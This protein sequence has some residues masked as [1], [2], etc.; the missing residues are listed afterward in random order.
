MDIY[1]Q[2][3][4][5]PVFRV[6]DVNQF[7]NNVNSARSAIYRLIGQGKVLKIRNDLYTCVSAERGGPV[8]N[9]YQIAGAI[10]KTSYISHH[11][12]MEYYGL[13]EQLYY[14]VY[15]SS[16]TR[17]CDFLFEDNYYHFV[18]S[19]LDQGVT[20]LPFSGGIKVT[21][22]E[23]TLVDCLKDMDKISGLE[24]T[25][26]MISNMVFLDEKKLLTY[27]DA[28]NNHFLYQKAGFMLW[29]DRDTLNLS[30]KFFD[31]CHS[32]IGKSKRYLTKDPFESVFDSYWN[33]VIPKHYMHIRNSEAFENDI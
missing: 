20:T 32:N 3:A 19:R 31:K 22:R 18:S 25:T 6:N 15:V 11:T 30:E 26:K 12:A 27:L 4:K 1:T 7:Y 2:L 23:R 33:L 21:D 13:A 24:E 29:F 16:K 8:A 17:F 14:D 28:Y 9:K 10:T 5:I